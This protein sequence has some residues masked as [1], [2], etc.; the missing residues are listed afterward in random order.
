MVDVA[1]AV[2]P[3]QALFPILVENTLRVGVEEHEAVDENGHR[4]SHNQN[5][6]Q[7]T[8]RPNEV[9]PRTGG[10]EIAVTNGCHGDDAP[11]EAGWNAT[12]LCSIVGEVDERR[13]EERSDS[14]EGKHEK[15][16]FEARAERV[17]EDLKA[18]VMA[19][20]FEDAQ[21][22][23][24]S[25]HVNHIQIFIRLVA[26]PGVDEVGDEVDVVRNDGDNLDYR[27]RA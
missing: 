22:A 16:I 19:Q 14:D 4:E 9:A 24:N 17:D 7:S 21:D 12:E 8:G 27:D 26:V 1:A 2:I 18:A 20:D 23:E 6:N 3:A 10:V 5:P 25:E 11:P 13:E 15:E